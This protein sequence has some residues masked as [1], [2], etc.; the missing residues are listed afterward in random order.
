MMDIRI[1]LA[2][3]VERKIKMKDYRK[4]KA[5]HKGAYSAIIQINAKIDDLICESCHYRENDKLWKLRS[6]TTILEAIAREKL[7]DI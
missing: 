6:F 2:N 7:D 5:Y 3:S 4:S 1:T